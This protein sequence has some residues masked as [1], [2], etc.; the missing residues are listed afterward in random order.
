MHFAGSRAFAGEQVERL[1]WRGWIGCEY[2]PPGPTL[3]TL[4]LGMPYGIGM[5]KD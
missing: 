4:G 1:G 5:Q 3:D 2:T